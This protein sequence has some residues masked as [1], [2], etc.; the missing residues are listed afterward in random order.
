MVCSPGLLS[1]AL[2]RFF[3]SPL[4]FSNLTRILFIFQ[5]SVFILYSSIRP[6]CGADPHQQVLASKSGAHGCALCKV[7]LHAPC[8]HVFF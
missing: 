5:L 2:W 8:L 7:E 4:R 6:E 3:G 1:P